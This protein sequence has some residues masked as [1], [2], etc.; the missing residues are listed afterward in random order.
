MAITGVSSAAA[1]AASQPIQQIG[2]H[3]HGKHQGGSISDL[4]AQSSSI[5]SAGGSNGQPGSK[6]DISV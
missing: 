3:K 6:V 4:D 5:A 1:Y 2:Q